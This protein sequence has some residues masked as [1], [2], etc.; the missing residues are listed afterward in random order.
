LLWGGEQEPY[1]GRVAVGDVAQIEED[2]PDAGIQLFQR[3]AG[4]SDGGDVE[5]AA[6]LH[7][8]S[9][10]PGAGDLDAEVSLVG[11]GAS[12]SIHAPPMVRKSPRTDS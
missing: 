6:Q 11:R 1:P 7:S 8:G 2:L 4:G 3:P 9:V 10:F 5:I 12:A